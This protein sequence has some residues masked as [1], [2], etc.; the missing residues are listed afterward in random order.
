MKK[1]ENIKK[2]KNENMTDEKIMHEHSN[3]NDY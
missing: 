2:Y 3:N 1:Y